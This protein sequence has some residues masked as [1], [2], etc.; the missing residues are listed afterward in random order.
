MVS[1]SYPSGMEAEAVDIVK[2]ERRPDVADARKAGAAIAKTAGSAAVTVL[3]ESRNGLEQVLLGLTLRGYAFTDHKSDKGTPL[4]PA[5]VF[6]AKP[7]EV[8][9]AVAPLLAVAGGVFFTRDLVSEPANVLTTTEFAT[10]L[11]GLRELGVEVEVVDED[12]MEELGMGALLCVGQGSVSPSKMVIMRWKGGEG[13]P[14]ALVGKGVVF[15]TGGI[16]L[17]PAGGMED[18]T[19]DMGGAGVVSGVMKALALRKAKANVTGLVGLVENMPSGNAV[20]PGDVVTSMK[21]DTIEVINTDAEGRLVLSDVLWYAQEFEQ[22]AAMVDLATLTGALGEGGG[23]ALG[24]E[25]ER[26]MIVAGQA[27]LEEARRW[28]I[29]VFSMGEEEER[30]TDH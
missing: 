8:E 3:G 19:M 29:A 27:F 25:A 30:E 13:A 26:T 6:C 28:K 16:S 24:I 21:G 15:D 2:L 18:M 14:L 12:R 17:K 9:A 1:L 23:T 20:R 22:P 7:D 5:R 4:A 10:R 11:E